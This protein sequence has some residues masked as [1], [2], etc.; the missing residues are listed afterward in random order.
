MPMS[1][2]RGYSQ[3]AQI[4]EDYDPRKPEYVIQVPEEEVESLQEKMLTAQISKLESFLSEQRSR[5]TAE[6]DELR[7]TGLG[8]NVR[9]HYQRVVHDLQAD[10]DG[11]LWKEQKVPITGKQPNFK[12]NNTGW[13]VFCA[14]PQPASCFSGIS[15]EGR[16]S[17]PGGNA[18]SWACAVAGTA[19]GFGP[20]P[21]TLG[22]SIPLGAMIGLL[23]G[24]VVSGNSPRN[25]SGT[26][27]RASD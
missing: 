11:K 6:A 19:L 7:G 5:A 2:A 27:T 25:S 13:S 21:F 22:L 16:G 12:Q 14:A 23:V 8:E 3:R 20:A 9:Q 18:L 15:M 17:P 4:E 26:S 24:E 1:A 10:Y